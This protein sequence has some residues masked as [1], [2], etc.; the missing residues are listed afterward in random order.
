MERWPPPTRRRAARQKKAT[1]REQEPE[2]GL[3]V[4]LGRESVPPPIRAERSPSERLMD[5]YF[6]LGFLKGFAG[7]AIGL[8]IIAFAWFIGMLILM[9]RR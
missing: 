6:Q 3:Q 4:T 8:F 2:L 1:E 9:G 5:A 7:A